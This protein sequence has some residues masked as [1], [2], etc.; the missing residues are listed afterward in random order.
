[1]DLANANYPDRINDEIT[2]FPEGK[3]ILLLIYQGVRS[4][5]N[6]LFWEHEG[7][8]AARLGDWKITALKDKD[9]ELF[10]LAEDRTETNNLA[11]KNPEKLNQLNKL[12]MA[13]EKRVTK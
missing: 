11:L 2:D 4:T 8:R 12:W 10:N 7:G 9:W 5:N 3:S 6:T 13:W 1:M